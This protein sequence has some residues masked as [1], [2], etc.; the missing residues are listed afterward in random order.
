MTFLLALLPAILTGLLVV[1]W[2]KETS[3]TDPS[4]PTPIQHTLQ[5]KAPVEEATPE[6]LTPTIHYPATQSR[7]SPLGINTNE[8]FEQDASIPFVD[9]FRVAT[10]FHENIRCRAQDKPCLTSAEVEYDS[11]GWPKSLNGGKAGVFF[12]RNIALAALPEGDFHVLYDGEG[13]LEYFHNV[14]VVTREAGIDTIRFNAREDGFM[15]A[16]LQIT[17]SNP[18]KPLK[19][20]RILM[21]GGICSDNPFRQV[22]DASTCQNS[23]FLD[24]RTH[25]KSITFNPD[26]L[27]FM[28]DFG[29]I[30]FM[31]MSGITRNPSSKWE[32]RP[33][34]QEATWGGIYGARGAPL[35][36]QIKLANILN[37]DP[38]LNVPHSADDHYIQQF[39]EYVKEH[40]SSKLT[41]YIE[42]TN[43]A[44]N[45]N[46]VHN[47]HMQKMGIAQKL[48]Q[49]ALL[50]GYKYYAKRSVEF[51]AI[52][53][54]VYGGHE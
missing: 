27:N 11:Q 29:V 32:E 23:D 14:E 16:A 40:L 24:F 53:E 43:E 7:E 35:E 6:I 34:M 45:A 25:Y 51:F 1:N 15:T 31:P 38:W 42:Y 49:D 30:R 52:W 9:L 3:I 5:T 33:N 10:P 54:A 8:V 18:A 50:A 44:W 12:L 48:D 37:A 39:A 2:Q 47:E 21:P 46:F 17:Q 41:P 28:K 26:Y 36:I 22:S 13:K 19:N 4:S 20:I